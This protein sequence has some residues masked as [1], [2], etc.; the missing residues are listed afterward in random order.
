MLGPDALH[1][2]LALRGIAKQFGATMVLQD[3]DLAIAPGEFISLVG[4][5]GCGKST[6]LR[7]IAGLEQPD[8]GSVSLAGRCID[9]M[10]PSE[11]DV[12]MVFQSYALYPHLSVAQNIALPLEMRQLRWWQRWPI[13]RTLSGLVSRQAKAIRLQINADVRALA[14]TLQLDTLLHRKPMQLSGGQRQRVA[15]A[16]AM[17]RAPRVFLMDEPL[18]NLDARLRVHLRDELVQLH[19]RLR[20]T[21]VYVTHD[22]SEAMTMSD[23]IAVMDEGRILQFGTPKQLYSDPDNLQVARFIGSPTINTLCVEADASGNWQ[24]FDTPLGAIPG[25]QQQPQPGERLTLAVRPEYLSVAV[26]PI[27]ACDRQWP[28]QLHRIEHHGADDYVFL[29]DARAPGDT[30]LIA[31][32][33]AASSLER[34]DPGT[35]VHVGFRWSDVMRFDAA[36]LRV[37]EP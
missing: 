35:A 34:A 27:V 37:R 1:V 8:R 18:S 21:F 36:G 10:A 28:M 13:A 26:E 25:R 31:R 15:L 22:Q 2:D 23:R 17:I 7:V 5:S 6:L 33:P 19:R 29:V 12:A 11:R 4:P 9:E 16:R 32:L 14:Q 24:Y 20:V 3:I 30:A